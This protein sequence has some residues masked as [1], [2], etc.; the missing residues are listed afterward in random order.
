MGTNMIIYPG[1]IASSILLL[2]EGH[3]WRIWLWKEQADLIRWAERYSSG[4]TG[5]PGEY[6]D[7]LGLHSPCD[8]ELDGE[9]QHIGEIHFIK[10]QWNMEHVAHECSHGVFHYIRCLISDFPRK[11]YLNFMECEE[12]VCYPFGQFVDMA[13]RWLWKQN[14]NPRWQRG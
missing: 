8:I 14:P 3:S 13:Y 6:E 11:L 4:R 5:E 2:D 1:L 10:D 9:Y 7:T 12:E